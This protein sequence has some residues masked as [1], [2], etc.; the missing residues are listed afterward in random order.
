MNTRC[1]SLAFIYFDVT[2]FSFISFVT[3]TSKHGD[4]INAFSILTWFGSTLINVYF[5][6]Y[7]YIFEKKSLKKNKLVVQNIFFLYHLDTA[8]SFPDLTFISSVTFTNVAVCCVKSE[9]FFEKGLNFF[10]QCVNFIV[11]LQI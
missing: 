7:P 11:V 2:K 4:T 5:T 8:S 3:F 10:R 6:I 9:G 1:K